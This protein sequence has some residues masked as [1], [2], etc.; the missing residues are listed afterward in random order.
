M[1]CLLYTNNTTGPA[2]TAGAQIPFGSTVHRRGRANTLEGNNVIIRG[3]CS[4]YAHVTATPNLAATAEGEVSVTALIDGNAVQTKT[5]TAGAGG[6]Y[7]IVPLDFV[8]RGGCD[9]M[10]VLTFTVSAACTL[11]SFPV[12]V[13][14]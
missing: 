6:D 11:A 2:L 1:S 4:S 10:H 14:S 7:V 8:V 3:G 13:E 12:T 9:G 5:V